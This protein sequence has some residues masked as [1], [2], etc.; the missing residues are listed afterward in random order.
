MKLILDNSMDRIQLEFSQVRYV[1]NTN[2]SIAC[3]WVYCFRK[4]A[5][6]LLSLF[7]GATDTLPGGPNEYHRFQHT[8]ISLGLLNKSI[9]SP[10]NFDSRELSEY[11]FR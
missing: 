8:P 2:Y 1:M 10:S 4:C 5:P 6:F 3:L 9:K 7:I 11:K